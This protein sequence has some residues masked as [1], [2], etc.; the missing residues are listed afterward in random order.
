M[1]DLEINVD[2]KKIWLLLT[3]F[4]LILMILWQNLNCFSCN[5]WHCLGWFLM[6][7]L[8]TFC[9]E[10]SKN[11]LWFDHFSYSNSFC[12]FKVWR[13]LLLNRFWAFFIPFNLYRPW[14]KLITEI[15]DSPW[16]SRFVWVVAQKINLL[17]KPD[18]AEFYQRIFKGK[19]IFCVH[20]TQ[21]WKICW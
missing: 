10:H 17:K 6:P 19:H 8:Y 14:L 13:K 12:T 4:G 2:I 1:G 11:T 5:V 18:M 15:I 9:F 16:W 20:T 7:F 3:L 21:C